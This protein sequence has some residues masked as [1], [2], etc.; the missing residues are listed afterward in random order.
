MLVKVNA[1]MVLAIVLQLLVSF[2]ACQNRCSRI[3]ERREIRDLSQGERDAFFNAIK[4]LATRGGTPSDY[5]RI[6][7]IHVDF[8]HLIHAEPVFLPWHRHYVHYL[9]EQLR[10]ID[11]SIVIPYWNSSA[12]SQQPEASELF[13]PEF[14]GG[15]GKRESG[16]CVTD[17]PFANF[18]VTVEDDNSDSTQPHCLRRS[19]NNGDKLGSFSAYETILQITRDSNTFDRF[20]RN[21]ERAPHAL[22]HNNIGGGYGDFSTMSSPNDPIFWVHH[23]NVDYWWWNWQKSFPG[24]RD[25]YSIGKGD[26]Q[27]PFFNNVRVSQT[28]NTEAPPYCYRYVPQRMRSQPTPDPQPTSNPQEPQPTQQPAQPPSQEPQPSQQ[29]VQPPSQEPLQPP[30]PP[31]SREPLQPPPPPPSREP[32][33]PPIQ[34][35]RVPEA[36]QTFP[37]F[38]FNLPGFVARDA[39]FNFKGGPLIDIRRRAEVD[40][41][42]LI[43]ELD[44]KRNAT[45]RKLGITEAEMREDDKLYKEVLKACG[46]EICPSPTDREEQ[47]RL[48]LATRVPLYWIKRNKLGLSA[49]RS[50]EVK[51][52]KIIK[53]LNKDPNYQSTESLGMWSVFHSSSFYKSTSKSSHSYKKR[54]VKTTTTTTTTFNPAT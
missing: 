30:P 41:E 21:I 48:R 53:R 37:Q 12:D 15:S 27:L 32:L 18:L 26:E 14:M 45:L 22:P 47:R 43:K 44:A 54:T 31:P 1:S 4:R 51:D 2:V 6:S 49:T 36:V 16:Y 35:P 25:M 20:S 33:Q 42:S 13:T 5:D 40:V 50:Q 52:A 38:P 9:Q 39:F 11:P 17:G 29:P 28:F 8:N 3:D 46:E 19:F 23:G 34:R 24:A 10:T 7:K